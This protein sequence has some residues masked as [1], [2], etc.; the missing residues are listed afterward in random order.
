LEVL[1]FQ[2]M[3]IKSQVIELLNSGKLELVST[4]EHL[5][6]PVIERIYKKMTIKLQFTGIHVAGNVIING[7][8]R[9][10]ASQLANYELDRIR[11]IRSL[12]KVDVS[13]SVVKLLD[14][15]YDTPAGIEILNRQDAQYNGMSFEELIEKIK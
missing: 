14:V 12:A 6:L 7:H 1:P 13:W 9:Y 10:V 15:D 4:H 8:H 5:C 2:T 3:S 11:S